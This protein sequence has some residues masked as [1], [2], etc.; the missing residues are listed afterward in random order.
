MK[1]IEKSKEIYG[2]IEIPP[3]LNQVVRNTITMV[4]DKRTQ[5]FRA[6][7]KKEQRG[8][9]E[10]KNKRIL[11]VVP[12]TIGTAAAMFLALMIGL[13]SSE[14]FAMEMGSHPLFGALA[15]VLT[16][17]S[18]HG[19][20]E[21]K[22]IQKDIEVPQIEVGDLGQA[23]GGAI[24]E[25]NN[26]IQSIV[27]H[28]LLQAEADFEAYK[29]E[30]MENSTEAWEGRTM[31]LGVTYEI[32]YQ[33]ERTLSLVLNYYEASVFAYEK[34]YYYNI[35][36]NTNEELTL[37]DV[38]GEGFVSLANGQI[39]SQMKQRMEEDENV[40][41]WGILQKE[42]EGIQGFTTVDETTSFYINQAGNPVIT[43]EEYSVAPGYMGIQEFEIIR[44]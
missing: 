25:I 11:K 44:E 26:R 12:Y 39:I 24:E 38:L 2:N 21:E 7:G 42:E 6:E 43:F 14:A 34:A 31:D 35:N 1:E 27:D 15:R 5:A 32:K 17:R 23:A 22:G 30:F 18:Y 8:F 9:K 29:K 37:K 3:E 28:H 40:Y 10:K 16:V 36:L 33:D 19:F 4:T 41:Y 20:D 13:N